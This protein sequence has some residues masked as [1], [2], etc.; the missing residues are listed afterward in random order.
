M[1]AVQEQS[2]DSLAHLEERITRAVQVITSLR[3]ENSQIQQRLKAVQDELISA[4]G[5]RSEFEARA[6]QF[7][8]ERDELGQK[9]KHLAEELEQVAKQTRLSQLR[10]W[11]KK[12]ARSLLA[13]ADRDMKREEE[14]E[15][16]RG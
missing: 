11:A 12:S 8:K 4:N 9:V 6:D 13:M 2:I 7:E 5:A 1:E 3:N 16:R 15:V 10:R 14:E